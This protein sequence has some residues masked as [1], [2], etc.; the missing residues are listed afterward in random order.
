MRKGS[1]HLSGS[2]SDCRITKPPATSCPDWADNKLLIWWKLLNSRV[3][4]VWQRL[5]VGIK[6]PYSA[7]RVIVA[8]KYSLFLYCKHVAEQKKN[9][10][11]LCFWNHQHIQKWY[12]ESQTDAK[13][14]AAPTL[15]RGNTMKA[16]PPLASTIMATNLGLTEQ[17]LLS[18]VICEIRMSS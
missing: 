18:H 1:S 8:G 13:S 16:P 11:Q 10:H 4:D 15:L 6:L 9:I 7:K 17:K 14:H 5:K 3:S 12:N 2:K